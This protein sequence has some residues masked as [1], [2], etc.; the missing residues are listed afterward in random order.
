VELHTW[1]GSQVR[2]F[3]D[4]SSD[5]RECAL[6]RLLVMTGMRR[7]EALGL[8]WPDV[9]LASGRVSVQRSRVMAGGRV[10][11]HPPK[12]DHAHR[13]VPLDPVTVAALRSWK[14]RQASERLA[15]GSAWAEG[16]W[17]FTREDGAPPHPGVV[18]KRFLDAVGRTDLPRIRLH[19]LRHTSATLALAAGEH[20][21]VVQERLGHATIAQTMDT[22][23]HTTPALHEA[24]AA[25]LAALVDG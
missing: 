3:L 7:G 19:D 20:P 11:E 8:K 5:D 2:T 21:K 22:Y 14:A 13:S 1:S 16:G 18:S 4:S 6:W 24:A 9:D 10:L 25:R 12:T 23:S 15:A 17:V